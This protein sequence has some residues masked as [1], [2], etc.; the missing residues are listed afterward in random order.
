M[1]TGCEM[2]W[3]NGEEGTRRVSRWPRQDT[4]NLK[5]RDDTGTMK[6]SMLVIASEGI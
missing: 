4:Y 3:V 1:D 2:V 6:R 5:H